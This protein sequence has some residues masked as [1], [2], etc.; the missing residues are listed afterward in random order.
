MNY[1]EHKTTVLDY[2]EGT[3]ICL[4]CSYV[5]D[6]HLYL[7]NDVS[8]NEFQNQD[9]RNDDYKEI[10]NRLNCS[11]EILQDKL[12]SN[13]FDLYSKIKETTNVTL[14]EYCAVTGLDTKTMV[15]NSKETVNIQNINVMLEKYC[16]LFD[17][18][19]K[20]YTLIKEKISTKPHSGHPPLTVI[21][22]HIYMFIKTELNK[23]I[24]I[25][26]ICR[27]LGISSISIQRYRKYE[28]SFRS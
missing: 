12:I 3:T 25:K 8:S 6:D 14:K 17:L 7:E 22:Y 16:K 5:I 20:N 21:G 18:D 28:L 19:Y 11:Y 2:R 13:V 15:K 9:E 4:D 27:T 10:L 24:T 26:D 1:C 23:K